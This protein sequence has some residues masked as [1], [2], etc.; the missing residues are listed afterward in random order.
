MQLLTQSIQCG[1]TIHRR[2][3]EHSSQVE[4]KV[5]GLQ[6]RRNTLYIDLQCFS[7]QQP[8]RS[9]MPIVYFEPQVNSRTFQDQTHFPGPLRACKF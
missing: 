8:K 5:L 1:S 9:T 7:N 4:N 2:T 3:A 6:L